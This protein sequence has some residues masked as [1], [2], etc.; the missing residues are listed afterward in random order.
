MSHGKHPTRTSKE[1]FFIEKKTGLEHY[2]LTSED[3]MFFVK[4]TRI[5]RY[6]ETLP[7]KAM[8]S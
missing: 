6:L 1:D 8:P 2:L 4:K 7:G 5:E 3:K